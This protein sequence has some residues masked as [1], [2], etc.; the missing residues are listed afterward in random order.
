MTGDIHQGQ[1]LE[2]GHSAF[3]EKWFV[4]EGTRRK[5]MPVDYQV[6]TALYNL[7]VF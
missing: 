4:Y 5:W 6:S 7:G 1:A 3:P 2:L